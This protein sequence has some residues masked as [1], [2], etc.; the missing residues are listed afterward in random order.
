M[1]NA[2]KKV[3]L[4]AAF[5]SAS[6]LAQTSGGP[7]DSDTVGP[8][9]WPLDPPHELVTVEQIRA[10]FHRK[11]DAVCEARRQQFLDPQTGMVLDP[12]AQFIHH[13]FRSF[14][15]PRG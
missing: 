5:V 15:K 14:Q 13:S 7:Q 6:A 3:L 1:L 9:G 8:D 12:P 4:A 2:L 11:C 10:E